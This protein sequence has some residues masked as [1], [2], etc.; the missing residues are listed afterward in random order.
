MGAHSYVSK[1]LNNYETMFMCKPK[2]FATPMIEKDPPEIVTSALLDSIGIKQYES[3]IGALQWLV[4]LGG[5]DIHL[6]VATM[7]SYRCAPRQGYLGRLK[8]MYGYLR[9]NPSGGIRVRVNIPNHKS[10]ATPAQYGWCSSVYGNVTEAIPP[11]Q[12]VLRC[13]AMCTP[14]YQDANSIMTLSLVELCLASFTLSTRLLLFPFARNNR[15]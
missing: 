3:L 12:P 2:E 6:G 14:T 13:K 4:T 1:M 10:I 5:D 11:D 8:C 9:C 7:A 15:L